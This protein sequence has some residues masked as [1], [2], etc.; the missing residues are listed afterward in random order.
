[1]TPI[2]TK[3]KGPVS[4]LKPNNADPPKV[5][6]NQNPSVLKPANLLMTLLPIYQDKKIV[7]AIPNCQKIASINLNYHKKVW[8]SSG[9]LLVRFC[10]FNSNYLRIMVQSSGHLATERPLLKFFLFHTHFLKIKFN[11]VFNEVFK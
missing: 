11:E 2:W 3:N 4:T 8:H 7:I 6:N 9:T 1:M 10:V 5:Q